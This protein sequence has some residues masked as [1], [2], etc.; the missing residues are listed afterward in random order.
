MLFS[1]QSLIVAAI[2]IG[3]FVALRGMRVAVAE[4]PTT[5]TKSESSTNILMPQQFRFEPSW[6]K[7]G[8][9]G[10]MSLYVLMQLLGYPIDIEKVLTTTPFDPKKGCS[11]EVL[12][13][14]S[15]VLG[16]QTMIRF[17]NPKDL[18]FVPRPFILHSNASLVT[19]IGHFLVVV[20]YSPER[21]EYAT[22]N[23]D[24]DNFGWYPEAVVTRN[25]SGYVLVPS[26]LT[27]NHIVRIL[28]YEFIALG[29]IICA[30][31]IAKRLFDK[32]KVTS[33]NP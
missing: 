9:C 15:N 7:P 18:P 21:R 28:S 14:T 22:I 12:S 32:D 30:A 10:P 3:S 17:V 16:L 33:I 4:E 1:K 24:D 20:N 31:W 13:E 19:G 25:F 2:V 11:L 23:T 26:E 27:E 8:D 6:R 29:V 5:D